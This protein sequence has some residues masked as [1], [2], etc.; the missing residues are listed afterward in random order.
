MTIFQKL[1]VKMVEDPDFAARVLHGTGQ[2]RVDALN[3]FL[4]EVGF[5]GDRAQVLDDLIVAVS[6]ADVGAMDN[7][8]RTLDGGVTP[9]LAF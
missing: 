8:L 5:E 7:L 6:T 3:E 9:D 4:D 1:C 2:E